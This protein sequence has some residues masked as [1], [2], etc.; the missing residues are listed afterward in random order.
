MLDSRAYTEV[1]YIIQSMSDELRNKIPINIIQNIEVRMDKL[2]EFVL[3]DIETVELLDDTEKIL[4]FLYTEYFST[5]EEKK[6]I[7]DKESE[8]EL[9]KELE[10][11]EKYNPDDIFRN[12][13]KRNKEKNLLQNEIIEITKTPFYKKIFE[14]IKQILK[15][16]NN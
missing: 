13:I 5:E 8:F 2:Y 1:Y 16:K 12:N 7:L 3:D 6:V 10:K 9:K 4:A 11:R 14:K 15:K